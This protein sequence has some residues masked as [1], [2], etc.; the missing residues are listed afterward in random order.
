VLDDVREGW[1]SRARAR[2]IYGVVLAE[3]PAAGPDVLVINEAETRAA[4]D[5]RVVG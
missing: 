4:R 5:H 2:D 1:V 3:N